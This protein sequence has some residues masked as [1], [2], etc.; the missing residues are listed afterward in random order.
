MTKLHT[1]E[2][3]DRAV[4]KVRKECDLVPDV[5]LILGTGLGGLAKEIDCSAEI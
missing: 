1:R 4:S 3:I 5:A 2:V